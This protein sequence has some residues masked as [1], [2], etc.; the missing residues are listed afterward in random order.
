MGCVF[1]L[2][3]FMFGISGLAG[4]GQK[5]ATFNEESN[6]DSVT[7]MCKS[8]LNACQIEKELMESG[9]VFEAFMSEFV[10]ILIGLVFGFYALRYFGVNDS[11][12]EKL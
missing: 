3:A 2:A 7:R 4:V 12:A 6:F 5:I 9:S 1:A 10:L 8:D 11:K